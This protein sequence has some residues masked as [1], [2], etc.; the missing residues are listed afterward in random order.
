[1]F[2]Q[3]ENIHKL[4]LAVKTMKSEMPVD[5]LAAVV[6]PDHLHFIWQLPDNDWDYSKRVGRIKVLF[7]KSVGDLGYEAEYLSSS[8]IKHRE[9]GIWQRRFWES[10]IRNEAEFEAYAN[11]IHF[12]PVKH[13]YVSCPHQW[14]Y[15]S[16][17]RWVE[18]GKISRN[19]RCDCGD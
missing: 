5:I 17:R 4:R 6:L 16:F 2:Q 19:W 8:R 10:T 13:G 3:V 12:N 18:G 14:E 9:K 1:M 7:S 15:S 11:Y